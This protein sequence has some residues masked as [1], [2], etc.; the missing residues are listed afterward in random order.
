MFN[1]KCSN[2]TQQCVF[3]HVVDALSSDQLCVVASVFLAFCC[4]IHQNTSSPTQ[5]KL[6]RWLRQDGVTQH[7]S[8]C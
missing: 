5:F 7:D 3:V 2:H 8:C 6:Q 4:Q 1:V